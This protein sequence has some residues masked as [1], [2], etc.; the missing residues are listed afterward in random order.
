M[1]RGDDDNDATITVQMA[2]VSTIASTAASGGGSTQRLSSSG[3]AASRSSSSRRTSTTSA[4]TT[5]ISTTNNAI[6]NEVLLQY[7]LMA[8]GALVLLKII[9]TALNIVSILLLPLLYLYACSQCPTNETF[10][11]KKEL[12]RVMRGAHLPSEHQPK[13]FFEQGFNRLAASVTAELATSLGYE[14]SVTDCFGAGR[15]ACVTV[16]VAGYEYYWM[17]IFGEL[18]YIL[19][20]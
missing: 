4:A 14:I 20:D 3:A 7:G 13:G 12:K 9:F 10:D 1:N 6:N 8:F 18:I 17:G 2:N 11:A 19:Y 5:P 16:P 15:L